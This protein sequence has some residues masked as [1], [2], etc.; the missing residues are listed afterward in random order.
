MFFRIF[1]YDKET[2]KR[3][4][5]Q[6][7]E[8]IKRH[9]TSIGGMDVN[10]RFDC[11][12]DY[13]A[14][15]ENQLMLERADRDSI[16][17][18]E[19]AKQRERLEAEIM[20]KFAAREEALDT[21]EAC[22]KNKEQRISERE[23]RYAEDFEHREQEISMRYRAEF[24]AKLASALDDARHKL[25]VMMRDF[26][27]ALKASASNN[28]AA[29]QKCLD[30]YVQDAKE[31][32]DAYG[33][34]ISEALAE[35]NA[36]HSK[37]EQQCEKLVRMLF[38]RKSETW[39]P[40]S[41]ERDEIQAKLLTDMELSEEEK[42]DYD[43]CRNKIKAY[44]ER[45]KAQKFLD[46]Q[47]KVT[48]HGR[49]EIPSDMTRLEP[50]M[51]YPDGYK[52]HEDDF[53]II[54]Y[55]D[56]EVV[57]PCF[58]KYMVRIY[59]RAVVVRKDDIDNQPI[60]A[61]LPES[62]IWKSYASEELLSQLEV[63]KYCYHMPF[64]RQ[65]KMMRQEGFPLS[66]STMDGWHKSVCSALVPLYELQ[67]KRILQSLYLAGDGCPMP[68]I[69]N[70]KHRTVKKYL[71]ELRAIDTGIPLFCTAPPELFKGNGRGKAVIQYLLDDW[72]GH[73]FMCDA[74]SS[75]DWLSKVKGVTLCRCT[76]H[77]RREMENAQRENP[78]LAKEGLLLYQQIYAVE[79][80]IKDRKLTGQ[81]IV[82]FRQM[83]AKPAWNVLYLWCLKH[84]LLVPEGTLIMRA[85]KY[86]INHYDEL[87]AYLSIA[88]MPVD[89]ND[90]ERAIREMVM[91]KKNYLFCENELSCYNAAE[92]YSF[93]GACK[94]LGKS[95][96]RWLTFALKHVNTYQKE[97]LEELLPEN[98]VDFK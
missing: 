97:R 19:V 72:N 66:R 51:I 37:K 20:K 54:G 64:Y 22:L 5:K 95:P 16:V 8:N 71:I 47:N 48:S 43:S 3:L 28:P 45:I 81:E 11:L 91:G 90:T 92:M 1:V 33:K 32:E 12:A 59:K 76:A 13:T 61:D 56:K 82:D 50:I 42:A 49:N 93:F 69:D 34:E 89:N 60:E 36:K 24:D 77:A 46:L 88:E 62:I 31:T 10:E 4:M 40:D 7:E 80:M 9:S 23:N 86:L 17:K 25:M 96:E 30:K 52:G 26:I 35:A 41:G 75:Y 85:M 27:D 78:T 6:S 29:M 63:R 21:K 18:S 39:K 58:D 57:V 14:D 94:V 74:C 65:E 87:T 15:V 38:L 68:M 44:R 55:D 67:Q 83:Y 79:N 98:W 53:R 84:M 70:E 2:R 73:A